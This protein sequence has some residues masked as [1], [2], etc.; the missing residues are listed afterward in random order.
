M[1]AILLPNTEGKLKH[2]AVLQGLVMES[3][4]LAVVPCKLKGD[5][6]VPQHHDTQA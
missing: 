5:E 1:N 4:Q 2:L 6:H 3:H